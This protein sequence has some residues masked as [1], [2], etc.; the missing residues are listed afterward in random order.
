MTLVR[1]YSS[2][3]VSIH[4]LTSRYL[5]RNKSKNLKITANL[6]TSFEQAGVTDDLKYSINYAVLARQL[7]AFEKCHTTRSFS[8][9]QNLGWHLLHDV[10]FCT[11]GC[12][13]ASL[14]VSQSTSHSSNLEFEMTRRQDSDCL[15]YIDHIR[16][17]HLQTMTIIGVFTE[18]RFRRQPVV[19]DIDISMRLD[20]HKVISGLDESLAN[21]ISCYVEGS[22]FK[23]V[24]ALAL[25]VAKLV[26]QGLPQEEVKCSVH[27]TK[28][29]ALAD[30]KGVGVTTC[31]SRDQI[32][33]IDNIVTFDD[34]SVTTDYFSVPTMNKEA[35]INSTKQ[36]ISYLAFGTNQG[37]QVNNINRALKAL[38]EKDI[39]ILATSSLYRSKP[40]Y[41]LDQADFLNGCVK[42]STTLSPDLLLKRLKEIEYNVLKRV[43]KFDNGPRTIDLDIILYDSIIL[44]SP[45]LN[46][47]HIRMLERTFVMLP[48]CELVPPNLLHPVTAEPLHQHLQQLVNGS[49]K[50]DESKQESNN[51]WSIVPLPQCGSCDKVRYMEYDSLGNKSRTQLMGILNVTPDSFSDGSQANLVLENCMS[52]VDDM[53]LSKVDIIDVGGCSTRPG[54]V[55]PSE[56]EELERVLPVVKAIKQKYGDSIIVSI[57]TY[58]ARIAEETIKLGAEIIN[59]ISAGLFD[60]QMYSVIAKYGVPYVINHTRGTINTMTQLTDYRL[61]PEEDIVL[62]NERRTEG[63]IVV[64]EIGKELSTLVEK[65]YQSGIR[66]WQL[67]LDPGLG[68]AKGLRANVAVIKNQP[69]FKE[70]KQLNRVTGSYIAFD[71][72]PLL[73]G[74]SRKRFIGTITGKSPA[75]ERVEGTGACVAAG[76][77]F[78][79]DI[80]RVHD[81][82]AM[83]DVCLMCDAIYK[84]IY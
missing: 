49:Q 44:N 14:K 42:V 70:Y 34:D 28:P 2:D 8:S 5:I 40:M 39:H 13:E 59:D 50:A 32:S 71:H 54:S 79:A 1:P 31:R 73:L 47:P 75:K 83:K 60:S 18:E 61:K 57:D 7:R 10:V 26:L 23:T 4:D 12:K 63:E 62:F 82:R 45:K 55:Q 52:K 25:N 66:R 36:H 48:L 38:E 30:A 20:R 65:M 22:N 41:F 19:L 17:S 80:V 35:M 24:E 33:N 15:N 16:L 76:I 53:V 46:I 68:F 58:R 78:G 9:Y 11:T 74:P 3:T 27:V 51:L 43:K 29:N 72:L 6:K 64:S 56:E 21:K 67:I 77:G 84:D 81:Y 69:Y 37:N